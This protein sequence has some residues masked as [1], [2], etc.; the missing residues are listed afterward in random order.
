MIAITGATGAVGGRVAHLLADLAP[1]LV[2]RDPSRAPDV[3]GEVR[4]A[5]YDD[6]AAA[7]S[8]LDG[9]ATLLLVSGSESA[10]RR[11]QHRTMVDAAVAAGVGHVVYTSFVG[12]GPDATFTLGR[13]HGDTE[14]AIR[15]SG[16]AFTLLRDNFYLD[17]LPY[18][19][20]ANGVIRG[21][22]GSG[23]IAAVARADVA[24]VAAVVLREPEAH[25]GVTYDLTGPESLTMTDVAAR[26]GAALGRDLRYEEETLE[27]AYASRRAAYP[28]AADW[29]L[30]AWVSTYTAVADGS[31]AGISGD[32]E[33]VTAHP[34][35]TLEQTLG[36]AR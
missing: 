3:G 27:E 32:V 36:P 18:F 21:P 4:T 22:A 6:R 14:Q 12:A 23:R 15:E 34:A 19:A 13:D 11:A 5:S 16:L 20:D 8:A 35:R 29:Q 1:R 30:D 24:D 7:V 9:V 2:V 25:A 31:V 28:D 17:V 33:R 10:D 26:A